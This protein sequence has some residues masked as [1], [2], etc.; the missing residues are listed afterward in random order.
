MELAHTAHERESWLKL[1]SQ[2]MIRNCYKASTVK[3]NLLAQKARDL[4][5][6]QIKPTALYHLH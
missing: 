1:W 5:C 2:K 3:G 4:F 6:K